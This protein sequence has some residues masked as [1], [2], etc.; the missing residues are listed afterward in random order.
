MPQNIIL[1]HPEPD[2]ALLT[3]DLPGKG[4]NV[5]S[6][7]VLGEL[8]KHLDALEKRTDLAGII[9]ISGKPG[10][11]VAGA[12]L[13]EFVASVDI[14]HEQAVAL[15]RHGQTLFG[16]LVKTPAVTVAAIDGVALGGG[17]ELAI[18]CDRRVMT[19]NPKT[20]YGFPE[21]KL[22]LYPGWGGTV[23][24]PRMVGLGNAA[25]MITAGE[26]IDARAAAAMGLADDLV[27]PDRLLAA[28]IG[29]VRA[30]QKSKRYLTDRQRWSKPLSI[31][32]TELGFLGATF[33]AMILQQ[34]KGHYPAPLAALELMLE[35]AA[36]DEEAALVKEAEGMASFFGSPVNRAL[37]NVFFLTDRNKKD[38]GVDRE[39]IRP[40]ELSAVGVI[41]A[42]IMGSGIA[43][44]NLKRELR[45]VLTDASAEA[46][47]RGAQEVIKEV[48]YDKQMG[49]PDAQRAVRFAPLLDAAVDDHDFAVCDLVIEAVVENLDVKRQVYAR[50]E[51]QLGEKTILASNTSTI[52]ITT[53]AEGVKRRDRFCG[54]HF[55]NPVRRM[56]LVEVIRGRET[57][58]ET[59]AT[60][61]AHVKRL[62]KSP[63]VC[64]DGPGFLVNRLLLP[65]MHEALEL[66]AAGVAIEKIERAATAFGMPMGP[67]SLYDMV[68]L[69][70]A[71]FA[72]QTM[73]RAYPERV[74][75]SPILESLVKAGRLGTKSG[76]GFFNYQNKKKKAQPDETLQGFVEPHMQQE[77]VL[78]DRE[79]ITARLF[80]PMLLEATRVLEEGIV[81]DVRDVDL[82][83]IFGI[84]F[85]PFKGGLLFW[86]DTLGANQIVEML[87]PLESLGERAKPTPMLLD[88]AKTDGTFYGS[89]S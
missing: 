47:Q 54:I 86:A 85:P 24:G 82:G 37:L 77:K 20:Q 5:L 27:A 73:A 75:T 72:G 11:F 45:V 89:K 71:L 16:R 1:S 49:G 59:V 17:A 22:G 67:I 68:G 6:S 38:R 52:P 18:W 46:L 65:Y 31:D 9:L 42:G 3:I 7:E 28:A 43:A 70:T 76:A 10:T 63:I 50:L 12:D 48:A 62:G 32:E 74:G 44:A 14:P 41:G 34:T 8:S 79:Q 64:N 21:V 2:I 19:D 26:S 60:A 23:R 29:M 81:R 61:V 56:K 36:L 57:S 40:R 4:A 87:K 80:L 39:D 13:R 88:L 25:E 51:P 84:G 30:E 15:C 53:L 83:L 35:C 78:L 58:D 66:L 33:S 69:D 55:F